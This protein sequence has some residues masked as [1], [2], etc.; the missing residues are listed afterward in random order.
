MSPRILRDFLLGYY[1]FG[2]FKE[3]SFFL[4]SSD[5]GISFHIPWYRKWWVGRPKGILIFI[6]NTLFSSKIFK[7]IQ[8]YSFSL[9]KRGRIFICKVFCDPGIREPLGATFFLS[10]VSLVLGLSSFT[11]KRKIIIAPYCRTLFWRLVKHFIWQHLALQKCVIIFLW[12]LEKIFS[13]ALRDYCQ[14]TPVSLLPISV[15]S[16]MP[17]SRPP[18]SL[19]WIIAIASSPSLHYSLKF[20]FHVPARNIISKLKF[21][22][23][24]SPLLYSHWFSSTHRW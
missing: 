18:Q 14:Y 17:L 22:H 15:H 20:I 10:C 24:L 6:K 4:E 5:M 13:E 8:K 16:V 23:R 12:Q 3:R 11:S 21:A 9:R 2:Y 1:W 7:N 19:T